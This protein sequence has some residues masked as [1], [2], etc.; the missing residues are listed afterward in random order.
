MPK[1][2]DVKTALTSAANGVRLIAD[3]MRSLARIPE[4]ASESPP[5]GEEDLLLLWKLHGIMR[6]T[7]E[8]LASVEG[9]NDDAQDEINREF[10]IVRRCLE[11]HSY[12]E[13]PPSN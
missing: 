8:L 2:I 3:S 9:C 12:L 5:A 11:E 10:G 1:Q 4:Q 6:R 7:S 13:G